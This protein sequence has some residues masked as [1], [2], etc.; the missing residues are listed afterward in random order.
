MY[1]CVRLPRHVLSSF[2]PHLNE[3]WLHSEDDVRRLT[4]EAERNAHF[5][6]QKENVGEGKREETI[7]HIEHESMEEHF[8]LPRL[9]HY[10]GGTGLRDNVVES[11]LQVSQVQ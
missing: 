2:G 6:H 10:L 3:R 7:W 8:D 5:L 4:I 1:V 9:A 11:L